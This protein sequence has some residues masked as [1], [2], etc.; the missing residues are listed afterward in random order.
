MG[1]FAVGGMVGGL[2]SGWMADKMG[3]KGA[4]LFNNLFAFVAA[5]LMTFAKYGDIYYLLTLGR[6][7]IGFSCG[8]PAA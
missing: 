2:L 7:V 1:I 3:R 6:L 8:A 5:A 4:L